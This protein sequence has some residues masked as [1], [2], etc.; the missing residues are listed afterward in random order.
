MTKTAKTKT[1]DNLKAAH[2][3]AC[4]A[5]AEAAAA[6]AAAAKNGEIE[7]AMMALNA[8]TAALM[9]ADAAAE[10]DMDGY[11]RAKDAYHLVHAATERHFDDHI[12][13]AVK[14]KGKSPSERMA[15]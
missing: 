14:T 1:P 10:G 11:W 2:D 8:A 12:K 5:A 13:Q 6:A 4:T 9:A 15:N 7:L 3:T